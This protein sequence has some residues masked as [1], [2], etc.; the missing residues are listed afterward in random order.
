[1]SGWPSSVQHLGCGTAED[2]LALVQ[3]F[4]TMV[5]VQQVADDFKVC[6]RNRDLA[7]ATGGGSSGGGGG[8]DLSLEC[9]QTVGSGDWSTSNCAQMDCGAASPLLN[10]R[11]VGGL[12]PFSVAVTPPGDDAPPVASSVSAEGNF[13][14]TPPDNSG[15]GTAGTAYRDICANDGGWWDHDLYGC[16]DVLD[17]NSSDDG[18]GSGLRQA[19]CQGPAQVLEEYSRDVDNLCA[20]DPQDCGASSP[21][22]LPNCSTFGGS[23]NKGDRRK[24]DTRTQV[25]IDAG[26][27]PCGVSVDGATVTVT[28]ALGNSVAQVMEVVA[29]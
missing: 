27:V 3:G 9:E 12:G 21:I 1:V 23:C 22:L 7:G 17:S 14:V 4:I 11:V 26:C 6:L 10:F 5:E 2:P 15:S 25:M 29:T 28:D 13:Q 16:D 8:A 20:G 24:C 18:C 19:T